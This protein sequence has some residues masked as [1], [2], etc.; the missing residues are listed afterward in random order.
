MIPCSPA[1]RLA[2][3]RPR[4]GARPSH[5]QAASA[6]SLR[7]TG[8]GVPHQATGPGAASA[9]WASSRDLPEPAGAATQPT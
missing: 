9:T 7:G 3:G 8:S 1:G 6:R 4:A 2:A 5:S